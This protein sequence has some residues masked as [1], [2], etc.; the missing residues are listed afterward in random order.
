MCN[1]NCKWWTPSKTIVHTSETKVTVIERAI[2][3]LLN[4]VGQEWCHINW[5]GVFSE[6]KIVMSNS[7]FAREAR[8]Q[9]PGE[10]VDDG[11]FQCCVRIG[12][13]CLLCGKKSSH[14]PYTWFVSMKS[15]LSSQLTVHTTSSHLSISYFWTGGTRL[16]L[17][18]CYVHSHHC[19]H[20]AVY[21][22]CCGLLRCSCHC[23]RCNTLRSYFGVGLCSFQYYA[24]LF[25]TTFP[26]FANLDFSPGRLVLTRASSSKWKKLRAHITTKEM[27]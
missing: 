26:F 25:V 9:L 19:A 18:V 16:V 1:I 24:E 10:L 6:P 21:S 17:H 11:S 22:K 4:H 2:S 5:F 27:I 13:S 20:G 23:H 14:F 15:I 3:S 7:R 8:P 12:R